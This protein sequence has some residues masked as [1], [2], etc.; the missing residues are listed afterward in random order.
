[1]VV[2]IE[3]DRGI[4][5]CNERDEEEEEV[6]TSTI[7]GFEGCAECVER[8]GVKEKV[9]ESSVEKTGSDEAIPL[10]FCNPMDLTIAQNRSIEEEEMLFEV[11]IDQK[12]K[13][14][15]N[16]NQYEL[17]GDGVIGAKN[18]LV[19]TEVILIA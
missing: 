6:P 11:W 8:E 5:T 4:R 7:E 15:R 1:L 13:I 3:G 12:A 2:G 16:E 17:I 9:G 18:H 19:V 14:N 10:A